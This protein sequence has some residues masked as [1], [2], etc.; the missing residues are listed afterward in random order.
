MWVPGDN[1][2][3]SQ[4]A[5]PQTLGLPWSPGQNLGIATPPTSKYDAP[6]APT[7]PSL[8]LSGHGA[9]AIFPHTVS[10]I[11]RSFLALDLCMGP[12]LGLFL[13]DP[14]L[15]SGNTFFERLP[16]LPSPGQALTPPAVTCTPMVTTRR[17]YV[18][19]YLLDTSCLP[20]S[21]NGLW[22]DWLLPTS[23]LT[24]SPLLEDGDYI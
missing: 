20:C 10:Q 8:L 11:P 18:C 22:G 23:F 7:Q 16:W 4:T 21:F 5:H 15:S 19:D 9:L 17:N 14:H 13:A 12:R 3:D 1:L 6:P 24:L 2:P